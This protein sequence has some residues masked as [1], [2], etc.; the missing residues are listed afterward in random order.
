MNI[1]WIKLFL[2]LALSLSFFSAVADRFGMWPTEISTWGS[3][4]AFIAYTQL[5]NPW[6]PISLIPALGGLA[7]AME[8]IFAIALLLGFKGAFDYSVFSASAAAF[9]LSI[10]NTKFLELDSLLKKS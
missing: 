4:E 7:T 3:W 6:V 2:R 5:L 10:I 8:V 1:K 9:A